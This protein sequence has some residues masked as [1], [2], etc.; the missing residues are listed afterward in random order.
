MKK[1]I[2]QAFDNYLLA[3]NYLFDFL[4]AECETEIDRLDA[5]FELTKCL[6]SVNTYYGDSPKTMANDEDWWADM[7]YRC[8]I[9]HFINY[10]ENKLSTFDQEKFTDEDKKLINEFFLYMYHN[11]SIGA[12]NDW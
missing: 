11:E 12:Q 4:L 10:L 9:S 2:K 8:Q 7:D 5:I 3:K 1:E 6:D